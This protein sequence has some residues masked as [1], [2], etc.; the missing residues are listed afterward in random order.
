[1][2]VCVFIS[3]GCIHGMELLDHMLTLFN[4]L[5]NC[6][7]KLLPRVSLVVHWLRLCAPNAG[8][9]VQSLLRELDPIK[10][11]HAAVKSS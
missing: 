7:Q 4:S 2:W 1:M 5:R 3:L 6:Y 9:H 10:Y 11:L 8:A